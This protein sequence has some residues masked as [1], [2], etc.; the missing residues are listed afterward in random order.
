MQYD[1]GKILTAGGGPAYQDRPAQ[2]TAAVITLTGTTASAKATASMK[3]AR[4][5]AMAPVLPDGKVVVIGGQPFPLPFTDTDA[6]LVP[7][8]CS[9]WLCPIL[10]IGCVWLRVAVFDYAKLSRC[11]HA[12]ECS[13]RALLAIV[14]RA[15]GGA[16]QHTQ[17]S[18]QGQE[19]TRSTVCA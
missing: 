3:Y 7:G 18:G 14:Q 9:V 17:A 11:R 13:L 1:A 10:H 19:K 16:Q 15:R 4:A 2:A 5:Y 8:A 6:V 12:R